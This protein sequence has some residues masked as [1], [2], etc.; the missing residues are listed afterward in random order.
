[1]AETVKSLFLVRVEIYFD[2]RFSALGAISSICETLRKYDLFQHFENWLTNSIFPT[3]SSWKKLVKAKVRENEE[4]IWARYCLDHPSFQLPKICLDNV[5]PHRFWSLAKNYPDLVSR[6]HTQTRLMCNFGLNAGV[7]WLIGKSGDSCFICKNETENVDHLFFAC[8][9]F[10]VNF[11]LVWSKLETKILTLNVADGMLIVSFIRN[12]DP[13]QKCL[14]LL[15]R[16]DLPFEAIV[17]TTI[18]KFI[19]S[20]V[21]KIYKLLTARLRELEAP[22]L[23]R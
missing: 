11:N 10:R 23:S 2:S 5:N 1:M 8:P 19:S 22:S 17:V 6:L 9:D 18:I 4:R 21:A 7:P 13:H 12:L 16:L 14:L 3:Y 15:G 20:A